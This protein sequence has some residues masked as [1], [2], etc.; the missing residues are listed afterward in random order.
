MIGSNPTTAT[1]ATTSP[2]RRSGRSQ[3]RS[4]IATLFGARSI[5]GT[6]IPDKRTVLIESDSNLMVE[7]TIISQMKYQTS[8]PLEAALFRGI[9]TS[10][11]GGVVG[12]SL[13]HRLF[14]GG[15]VNF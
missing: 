3:V 14:L 5:D 4:T 13:R 11:G 9:Q 1:S 2:L 15:L 12:S 10:S 8:R 6:Y 7:K